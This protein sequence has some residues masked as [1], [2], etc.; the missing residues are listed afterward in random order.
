VLELDIGWLRAVDSHPVDKKK[1]WIP[2]LSIKRNDRMGH[3][4]Q[5]P[6]WLRGFPLLR[7]LAQTA[8]RMKK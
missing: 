6:V 3:G 1:R 2:T 8:G 5:Y 7:K 4:D